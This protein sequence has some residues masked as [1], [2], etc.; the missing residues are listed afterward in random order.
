MSAWQGK[1]GHA[2]KIVGGPRN[3]P[4]IYGGT[5]MLGNQA[6]NNAFWNGSQY[7]GP[8]PLFGVK[9]L[10]MLTLSSSGPDR[11]GPHVCSALGQPVYSGRHAR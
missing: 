6:G 5:V 9:G 2:A 1:S 4:A 11:C 10:H 3:D 8:C 7:V